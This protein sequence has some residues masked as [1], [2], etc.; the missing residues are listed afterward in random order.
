[1]GSGVVER[2]NQLVVE[3]RL[4]GAGMHWARPNVNPVNPLRILRTAG[5]PDRGVP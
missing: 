3:A 1:M 2:A 4:T 5:C